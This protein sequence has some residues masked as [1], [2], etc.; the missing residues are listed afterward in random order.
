[1]PDSCGYHGS[2]FECLL[3]FT[4]STHFAYTDDN[5]SDA[6][7]ELFAAC[8]NAK[9]GAYVIIGI[10]SRGGA[11]CSVT[12]YVGRNFLCHHKWCSNF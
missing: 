10:R 11:G 4:G 3:A 12:S 7:A 6:G 5:N 8:S 2:R 1:M 9:C